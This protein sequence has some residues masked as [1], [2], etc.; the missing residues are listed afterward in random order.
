MEM[1]QIFFYLTAQTEYVLLFKPTENVPLVSA[2][3]DPSLP[4]LNVKDKNQMAAIR[5]HNVH[6]VIRAGLRGSM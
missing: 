4:L 1:H 3:K 6:T 5:P 2:C